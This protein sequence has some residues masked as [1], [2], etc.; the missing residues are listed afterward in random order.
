MDIVRE[1][2]AET[3]EVKEKLAEKCADD[4]VRAA[5]ALTGAVLGWRAIPDRRSQPLRSAQ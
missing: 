3:I 2:I 1:R 4:I 5:G